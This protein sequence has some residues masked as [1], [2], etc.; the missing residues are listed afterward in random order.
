MS[1]DGARAPGVFSADGSTEWRAAACA[2][3]VN[4]YQP[5]GAPNRAGR[6]A[7]RALSGRAPQLDPPVAVERILGVAQLFE[8]DGSQRVGEQRDLA[9]C[10]RPWRSV[11]RL[12]LGA[13]A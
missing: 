10:E 9:G 11:H 7:T 4:P 6:V 3:T 2:C 12:V 8:A 1:R 13:G 5:P